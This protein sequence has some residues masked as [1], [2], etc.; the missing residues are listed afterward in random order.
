MSLKRSKE[1][2][3]CKNEKNT[4]TWNRENTCY[5]LISVFPVGFLFSVAFFASQEPKTSQPQK[6]LTA[7]LQPAPPS[8]NTVIKS[9]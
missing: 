8:P 2:M 5:I 6:W 7:D 4:L 1:G 3:K 9:G